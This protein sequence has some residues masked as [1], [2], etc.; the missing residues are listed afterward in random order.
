[1]P[2]ESA[3]LENGIFRGSGKESL[4]VRGQGGSGGPQRAN[5]RADREELPAGARKHSA[6]N[7][8]QPRAACPVPSAAADW[9][10]AFLFPVTRDNT[11][12]CSASITGVRAFSVVQDVVAVMIAGLWTAQSK[13]D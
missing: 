2:D 10:P 4:D 6:K 1:M 3:G 12:A 5:Q 7:T 9:F 13:E 11:A 8:R